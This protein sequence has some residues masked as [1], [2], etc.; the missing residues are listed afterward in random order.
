MNRFLR[1][2]FLF[3]W[4]EDVYGTCYIQFTINEDGSV[5]DLKLFKGIPGCP[6]CDKEVLRVFSKV[7]NFYPARKNCKPIKV[8]YN[9]PIKICYK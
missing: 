8:F 9:L 2:N 1:S 4:Q 7:P 3:S 6:E 5:T